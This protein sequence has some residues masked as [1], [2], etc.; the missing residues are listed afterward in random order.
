[1]DGEDH[2][3][4]SEIDLP[5]P[6]DELEAAAPD[7]AVP[8]TPSASSLDGPR[9]IQGYLI[10]P[11]LAQEEEPST[12][13]GTAGTCTVSMCPTLTRGQMAPLMA[14]PP[15]QTQESPAQLSSARLP[16]KPALVARFSGAVASSSAGPPP[17]N[18][19]FP[20]QQGAQDPWRG[21]GAP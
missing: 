1:M 13:S 2:G 3:N 21:Q 4:H 5:Q 9:C 6:A 7:A 14:P 12:S 8:P 11:E 16:V 17:A 19:P 10:R 20:A 18:Q 15:Q